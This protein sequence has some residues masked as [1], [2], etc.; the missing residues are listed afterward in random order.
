MASGR[1]QFRDA[2]FKLRLSRD[3]VT[4]G[5]E[6]L[7]VVGYGEYDKAIWS[8]LSW[9]VGE[10]CHHDLD[11]GLPITIRCSSQEKQP[12]ELHLECDAVDCN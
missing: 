9:A 1:E 5:P 6:Q 3:E 7:A 2:C 4:L 10:V 8:G 12:V 11:P